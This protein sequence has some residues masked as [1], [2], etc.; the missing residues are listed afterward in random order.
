VLSLRQ[1]IVKLEELADDHHQINDFHFGDPYDFGADGPIQYPLMGCML[2]PGGAL[3][4]KTDR[5]KLRLYF[6][7]LV[8]QDLS[9]KLEVLSDQRRTAQGIYS[10]FRLWLEDNGIT[11]DR[12]A[13]LDDFEES[14]DDGAFGF[15][16]DLTIDQFFST[17]ACW[18]PSDFDPSDERA[19]DVII[20]NITTGATITTV[21]A[22]G[23][24][25]VLQFSGINDTGPPYT[26]SIVDNG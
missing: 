18:E 25:G 19:G 7:D 21:N 11:L 22:G 13:S 20:F 17:D 9:N 8:H 14:W 24:Y 26:N 12:S 2:V 23:S 10:Q 16:L 15:S 5:L 1:I 6:A 4:N 3:D